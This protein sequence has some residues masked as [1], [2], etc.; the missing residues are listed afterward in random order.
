LYSH[1]KMSKW[2]ERFFLLLIFLIPLQKYFDK[3]FH[4][5]LG[6]GFGFYTTDI[7]LL[8][9]VVCLLKKSWREMLWEGSG[10]FLIFFLGIA[11]ISIVF[12]S[13]PTNPL[14]YFKLLHFIAPMIVLGVVSS[15][16]VD[17]QKIL[18]VIIAVAL[19]E[20]GLGIAQYF[21]QDSL[22]L[23]FLGEP[24][25][26]SKHAPG[27]GFWMSDGT[28]WIVDQ[29]LGRGSGGKVILRACGT[30]PHPNML[31]GFLVFSLAATYFFFGKVKG[32]SLAVALQI[33]TIFLTFSRAALYA[34]LI[35]AAVW[36]FLAYLRKEKP[37]RLAAVIAA[38]ALVSLF[39]LYPQLLQRGGVVSY[40]WLTKESDV[41]RLGYQDIAFKMMA[42]N[43]FLGV[44]FDHFLIHL[45]DYEEISFSLV[46]NIYLLIGSE[47]GLLGLGCF[48]LLIFSILRRGWGE[49][50][51]PLVATALAIFLGLLALGCCDFYLIF[52]QQGR[53]LF[54]LA[55]GL[56]AIKEPRKDPAAWH[57][58]VVTS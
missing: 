58:S 25:L 29:W 7:I 13:T 53:L 56:L 35:A 26:T 37:W 28:R 48:S 11:A 18:A 44:G 14:H 31:G 47:T 23:K 45:Q 2:A 51:D 19:L 12:S 22:G 10:K 40:T 34:S 32:I 54:F 36:F 3:P 17:S 5:F 52:H 42:D 50:Q 27:S 46:H 8:L 24:S 49:K 55:A 4:A 41:L 6:K 20:C 1:G 39:L 43:P 21:L 15:R 57:T 33:F 38:S 9:V 30:L 16:W